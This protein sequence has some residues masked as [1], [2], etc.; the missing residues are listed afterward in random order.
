M[1]ALGAFYLRLVYSSLDCYKYLEP[2]LNDYRKLRFMD[3]SG[4]YQLSHM[5][6]FIDLLLREERFCDIIM[7]RIQKRLVW[8]VFMICSYNDLI[9]HG[10][11]SI[12]CSIVV[13][14]YNSDL[15]KKLFDLLHK[16]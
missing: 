6:E 9:E 4:Q 1:R 12:L 16:K 10:A 13:N 15:I 8:T 7:P 2:L 3:R 5:D 11:F 14:I